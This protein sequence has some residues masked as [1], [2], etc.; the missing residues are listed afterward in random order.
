ME[1]RQARSLSG[2]PLPADHSAAAEVMNTPTM[3]RSPKTMQSGD[4]SIDGE[5]DEGEDQS[6]THKG[7]STLMRSLLRPKPIPGV[8]NFGILPEPEGEADEDVQVRKISKGRTD[9]GLCF[10]LLCYFTHA[11]LLKTHSVFNV[12]IYHTLCNRPKSGASSV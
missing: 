10:S 7:R 1:D 5:R 12:R 2:T 3:G 11:N 4:Q 9:S 8:E 6:S